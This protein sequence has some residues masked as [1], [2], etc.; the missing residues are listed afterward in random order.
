MIKDF[1]NILVIVRDDQTFLQYFS[2]AI[3]TSDNNLVYTMT[4]RK[5]E[6][7]K[8]KNDFLVALIKILNVKFQKAVLYWCFLKIFSCFFL[9]F[10]FG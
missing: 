2:N 1:Y 10:C 3:S 5:N 8:E 7:M 6:K 9:S 4:T